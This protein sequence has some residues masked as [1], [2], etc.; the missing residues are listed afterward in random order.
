M[1]VAPAGSAAL[2]L[3]LP[4]TRLAADPGESPVTSRLLQVVKGRG[5][6]AGDAA[7]GGGGALEC[8][9]FGGV[10][11][12]AG[13]GGDERIAEIDGRAAAVADGDAL[14]RRAR[15]DELHRRDADR[16]L[17]VLQRGA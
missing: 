1:V 17:C 4:P 10:E 14:P 2:L 8:E 13:G 11:R 7:D 5:G 3:K 9:A 15:R 6:R 12:E 16:Q